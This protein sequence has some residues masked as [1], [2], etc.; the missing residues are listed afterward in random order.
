M[1]NSSSLVNRYNKNVK[2]RFLVISIIFL[3]LAASMVVSTSIGV[4]D[5][6]VASLFS[7]ISKSISG[8]DMTTTT[9]K[10]LLNLRLPR[11]CLAIVAGFGLSISGCVM[12][13]ITRNPLVSPFTIGVSSAAAFGASLNIVFGV[14]LFGSTKLGTVA[15]AFLMAISCALLLF[16][17]ALNV[18]LSATSIVLTGTAMNY[19]FQALSTSVQFVANEA[20]L[21][22]VV[23][24]SFGSVNGA[25]WE[26]VKIC[27][28]ITLVSFIVL[29]SLSRSLTIISTMDDDISQTMGVNL[30]LVRG[31]ATIFSVI[32]T[33]SIISFTGIIGFVGLAAPH[34]ARSI[35][36]SDYKYFLVVAGF[37]G[38][39]L[40]LVS[41]TIGRTIFTPIMIPVGIVISFVGV[42][43]FIY[44]VVLANKK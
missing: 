42:P 31:T 21:A 20:Q 5:S 30:K 29:F 37:L 28:S 35:T 40:L 25:G 24:W 17:I 1:L 41:D 11:T 22:E 33:A 43:L 12:Q 23:A 10:V 14:G 6:T 15:T 32:T 19:F 2:I 16:F 36:G 34:I 3:L 7:T 27:S 9:E 18:G 26:D 4:T 8:K 38:A 13:G 44:Q 39:I